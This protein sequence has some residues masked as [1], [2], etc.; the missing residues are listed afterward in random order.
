MGKLDAKPEFGQKN[1]PPAPGAHS[2]DV[3]KNSHLRFY[4]RVLGGNA[5]KAE[6]LA[7]ENFSFGTDI[8]N[9]PEKLIDLEQ[10]LI[11]DVGKF[12]AE[13]ARGAAVHGQSIG[14]NA[15]A[16]EAL[17]NLFNCYEQYHNLLEEIRNN[18]PS[19]ANSSESSGEPH[20]Q[21]T[22]GEK[23]HPVQTSG[24]ISPVGGFKPKAP[25]QSTG[26]QVG[27]DNKDSRESDEK[28]SDSGAA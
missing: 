18:P 1:P 26:N 3:E 19:S 20:G 6:T 10:N 12:L 14:T 4:H 16:T 27:V 28:T 9:P 21:V 22:V 2:H 15:K 17:D 8:K 24:N 13:T 23:L 5:E 25:L 11:M 7:L